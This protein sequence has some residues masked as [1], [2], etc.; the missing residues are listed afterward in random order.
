MVLWSLSRS[1][2]GRAFDAIRQDETVAVALGVSVV[3]MH[4]L[5]FVLSGFLGGLGGALEALHNYS[6]TPEQFGFQLL[7]ACLTFVILGGRRSVWGPLAGALIL[8]LLPEVARPFKE[9]RLLVQGALLISVIVYLENG[10]VD[11]LID[12]MRARRLTSPAG[13]ALTEVADGAP[14]A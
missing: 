2:Y 6:I 4:L 8:T 1:K 11:T 3:Q 9:Y 13:P 12:R 14:V 7:V 5:A 10:I